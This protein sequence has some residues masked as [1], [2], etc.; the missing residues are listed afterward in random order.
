MTPEMSSVV[1]PSH[2]A[3]FRLSTG[4]HFWPLLSPEPCRGYYLGEHYYALINLVVT[5]NLVV[6]LTA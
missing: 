2:L 6:M 5:L 4:S 3:A 1:T